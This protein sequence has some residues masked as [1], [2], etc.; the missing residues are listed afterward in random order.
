M[1]FSK[2]PKK[3]IYFSYPTVSSEKTEKKRK[4]LL[5]VCKSLWKWTFH[6]IQYKTLWK[7]T[8]PKKQLKHLTSLRKWTFQKSQKNLSIFLTQQFHQKKQK[9]KEKCYFVFVN[10]FENGLFTKYSTKPFES[11]FSKKSKIPK[12][13]IFFFLP[14]SFIRKRKENKSVTLCL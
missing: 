14:N 10:P 13:S 12:K 8:F 4:V 7:R 2:I 1:N 9:R 11:D 3:S 5:C 6:Q